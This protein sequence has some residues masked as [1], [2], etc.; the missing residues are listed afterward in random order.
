[1]LIKV[2]L[3]TSTLSVAAYCCASVVSEVVVVLVLCPTSS[4]DDD[5]LPA[6]LCQA[7]WQ[8]AGEAAPVPQESFEIL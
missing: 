3:Y 1:M 6:T 8:C 2:W 4:C 7:I 5:V